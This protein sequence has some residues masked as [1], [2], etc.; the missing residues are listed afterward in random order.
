[1]HYFVIGL[2]V[3]TGFA[4]VNYMKGCFLKVKNFKRTLSLVLSVLM[5][6]SC[7]S[8]LFA[9]FASAYTTNDGTTPKYGVYT[10]DFVTEDTEGNAIDTYPAKTHHVLNASSYGWDG[11]IASATNPAQTYIAVSGENKGL[12][13]TS[14]YRASPTAVGAWNYISKTFLR[15]PDSAIS[16]TND[17][18]T[19][20]YLV[21][22]KG[23]T[24]TFII[25]YKVEDIS[26]GNTG[27]IGIGMF[28]DNNAVD[29]TRGTS[30]RVQVI[31]FS[32]AKS[33]VDGKWQYYNVT[34]NADEL[35][36]T[37]NGPTD[38]KMYA[39]LTAGS[40][41]Q[42]S[43]TAGDPSQ[44]FVTFHVDSVTVV[45]I[46]ND[47]ADKYTAFDSTTADGTLTENVTVLRSTS[48]VHTFD[49]IKEDGTS[50]YGTKGAVN[51]NLLSNGSLTGAGM[52]IINK[53]EDYK[54][55]SYVDET[56]MHIAGYSASALNGTNGNW[57]TR[58]F[59]LDETAISVPANS[60]N[61]ANY[62][63]LQDNTTYTFILK[64]R[65]E[66]LDAAY[67]VGKVDG[68]KAAE[69]DPAT[70]AYIGLGYLNPQSGIKEAN[71][72]NINGSSGETKAFTNGESP[73]IKHKQNEWQYLTFTVNANDVVLTGTQHQL[74]HKYVQIY[75]RPES[76][77]K[78]VMFHV[79]SLTV[80]TESNT[81]QN[82]V[83]L[84]TM[85]DDGFKCYN[86]T[87]YAGMTLPRPADTQKGYI[88]SHWVDANG[89]TVSTV[90]SSEGVNF[91]YSVYDNYKFDFEEGNTM[92]YDPNKRWG[93]GYGNAATYVDSPIPG[94]EGNT[95]IK[96]T[97]NQNTG[98]DANFSANFT[99]IAFNVS[100]NKDIGY[101]FKTSTTYRI[102]FKYYCE[103]S[104]E[105]EER[106]MRFQVF[107]SKAA[108]IGVDGNKI[109]KNLLTDST[110][111]SNWNIMHANQEMKWYDGY[112]EFETP[113]D[114][115]GYEYILFRCGGPSNKVVDNTKWGVVYMDD[116]VITEVADTACDNL[117]ADSY[118][119]IREEIA[120]NDQTSALRVS[121]AIP[122][123]AANAASEIGF[124]ALPTRNVT[125]DW[126]KFNAEGKLTSKAIS[127]R[128]K[129]NEGLGIK[130]SEGNDLGINELLAPG[131][132]PVADGQKAYQVI[133]T[134]LH[135]IGQ[136]GAGL[137]DDAISVVLYTKDAEG[138]YTYYFAN[139]VSY[140][141]TMTMY[142][143][144]GKDIAK[145]DYND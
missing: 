77:E 124:I 61:G 31:G 132:V 114:F 140:D 29:A 27:I 141:Q 80:I 128:V 62:L 8:A 94:D 79:D 58:A 105:E 75:V 116:F 54:G 81:E 66:S 83:T 93:V 47:I 74:E 97:E 109:A 118:A 115:Q 39:I 67:E 143:M 37:S 26:A 123:A 72:S 127:V 142:A 40:Q 87:D 16:L 17:R 35:N 59:V 138:N 28:D 88:G 4:C 20:C 43:T 53:R 106:G 89:N 86:A 137:R 11:G 60:P 102:S 73:L 104:I 101:K 22:D 144:V 119:S 145:Y 130:D 98:A 46:D 51:H 18:N 85:G 5:V 15:D 95:V 55:V 112:V 48:N 42:Y 30:G 3:R 99:N 6:V 52:T 9:T 131:T 122:E 36:F 2:W 7:C 50:A 125:A 68:T 63:Y 69:S 121:A 129:D 19:G 45:A 14:T 1:M 90:P 133:I 111:S 117:V 32:E 64:Y 108:G 84:V 33:S 120:E 56:G 23:V 135:K 134:G 10:Y 13:L 92:Q 57:A 76:G 126:Y 91:L 21:M 25:K 41:T 139:E 113:A 65:L 12:H 24:Y 44:G 49:F 71:I 78:L 103:S 96:C 100:G 136:P 70:G 107:Y 38:G 34:V 82:D 110:W